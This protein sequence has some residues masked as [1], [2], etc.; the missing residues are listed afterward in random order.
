MNGGRRKNMV[1]ALCCLKNKEE[2]K[3]KRLSP[4]RDR[5][6]MPFLVNLP[7]F[8]WSKPFANSINF[9]TERFT[10]NEITI[11]VNYGTFS[12]VICRLR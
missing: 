5:S 10:I 2:G 4:T 6:G 7:N 12:L 11:H 3:K 9:Q 1:T 8:Q